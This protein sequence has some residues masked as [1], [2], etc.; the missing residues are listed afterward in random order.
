MKK[1]KLIKS[2]MVSA[3]TVLSITSTAWAATVT[4]FND[5]Q[6]SHWAYT[7]IQWGAKQDIVN[8]YEDHTFKP[9]Q[10]VTEAE[11]L[12]MLVSTFDK[13]Q[14]PTAEKWY[15][16]YYTYA[17]EK[18]W[19]L[20]GTATESAKTK[21]ITRQTV[22]ELV[23][24]A[25]GYNYTGDQAVQYL[26]GKGL[27]NGKSNN[28]I[29]GYEGRDVLT[30]AEAIQ[31]LMN[32]KNAGM[33]ELQSRPE[34]VSSSEQLPALPVANQS[35]TSLIEITK[36]DADKYGADPRFIGSMEQDKVSEAAMKK[37]VETIKIKEQK[38]SFTIPTFP[39]GYTPYL[40]VGGSA[41]KKV[42]A[43]QFF[44][45]D[46]DKYVGVQLD[47]LIDAIPMQSVTITLPSG[48]YFWGAKHN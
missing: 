29:A 8:G 46:I 4:S 43:G 25:Q 27:S 45:Y 19:V 36:G 34:T 17:K 33:N 41:M 9:N 48:N 6:Q 16:G 10:N 22:A 35:N 23:V 13:A 47:V 44:E 42:S 14:S 21:V 38:L 2:S 5:V 24:G 39:K 15:S 1:Y 28:T 40:T 11:F 31:F 32:L 7:S 12:K 20:K 30:R 3:C 26:L 18:N 37:F